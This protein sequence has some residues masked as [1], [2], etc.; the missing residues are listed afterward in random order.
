MA[1]A[2]A[3]FTITRAGEDYMLHIEDESGDTLELSATYEQLDLISEAI[4]E[5]LDFDED[6]ALVV[7]DDEEAPAN[8]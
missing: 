4:D 7:E 8:D 3:Q 1:K 6:D 5:S 2:L